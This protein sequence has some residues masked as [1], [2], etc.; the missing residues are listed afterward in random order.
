MSD[1]SV[2]EAARRFAASGAVEDEARLLH[3]RVRT[4][5]VAATRLR[6]CA[7]LG[8]EASR[9]VLGAAAPA[10]VVMADLDRREW[11]RHLRGVPKHELVL[12]LVVTVERARELTLQVR[13]WEGP[14]ETEAEEGLEALRAW[15][16]DPTSAPLAP[17]QQ[18]ADRLLPWRPIPALDH[19]RRRQWRSATYGSLAAALNFP[20]RTVA[21]SADALCAAA[22]L[23]GSWSPVERTFT[24]TLIGALLM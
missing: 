24:S 4:G 3:E 14:P 23:A 8:D 16:R 10:P 6:A 11:K 19:A 18:Q 7:Y 2:R 15:L 21:A 22:Q 13:A 17:L 1:V 20:R 9:R 12:A 5:R